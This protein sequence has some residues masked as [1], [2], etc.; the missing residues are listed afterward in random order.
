MAHVGN[1]K[2]TAD[3]SP[4][5]DKREWLET[6]PGERCL[7]HVSALETSGRY[8]FV[9]IE[10]SPGDATTL[11]VHEKENEHIIVLEGTVSIAYGKEIFDAEAG[12]VATLMK[13]IPHAWG[14]RTEAP[15][16]LAII[17]FPGGIEEI[18]GLLTKGSPA[19][20]PELLE[21]FHV[22]HLGPAPF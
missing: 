15:L 12:E 20:F 2:T 5:R 11:H 3:T 19:E 18:L 10:S 14:N 13:G 22:K 21:R 1:K 6:R 17:A 16:R 4:L 7:I 8:S 9:E